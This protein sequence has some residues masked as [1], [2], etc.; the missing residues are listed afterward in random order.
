MD[1]FKPFVGILPSV[2]SWLLA[3]RTGPRVSSSMDSLLYTRS[4]GSLAQ[5]KIC[6]C[7]RIAF[8]TNVP[9][10]ASIGTKPDG[11]TV[12]SKA[13]VLGDAIEPVRRVVDDSPPQSTSI[14]ERCQLPPEIRI[15]QI[16]ADERIVGAGIDA[17]VI[18]QSPTDTHLR[19][20]RGSRGE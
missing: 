17:G 2:S 13:S 8:S 7:T 6:S 9:P 20:F 10:T 4:N 5:K 1:D 12:C 11:L 16:D 14:A 18:G 15:R 19:F 3:P